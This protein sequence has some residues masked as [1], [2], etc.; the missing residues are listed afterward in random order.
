MTNISENVTAH[1][2]ERL[3]ESVTDNNKA[4]ADLCLICNKPGTKARG[5]CGADYQMVYR[6]GDLEFYPPTALSRD[7]ETY[8]RMLLNFYPQI[9]ADLAVEYNL[10]LTGAGLYQ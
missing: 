6:T 9:I 8:A 2:A 10:E 3:A 4:G 7:P 1:S 5:L